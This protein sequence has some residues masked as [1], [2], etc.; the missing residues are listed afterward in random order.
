MSYTINLEF[1]KELA[2]YGAGDWNECFHCGNCTATC[3]LTE[4]GFLFPRKGIRNI[5]MGLE[6][7]IAP[8]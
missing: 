2:K 6:E 1:K 8:S 5:Q 7:K 3:P 4:D